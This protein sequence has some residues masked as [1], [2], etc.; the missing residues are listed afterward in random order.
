MRQNLTLIESSGPELY[1]LPTDLRLNGH[2][3]TM[4]MHDRWLYS[5]LRLTSSMAVRGAALDLFLLA[6]KQA[7]LGTLPCDDDELASLLHLSKGEWLKLKAETPNPLYGW[8]PCISDRGEAR[9]MHPVV[10]EVTDAT[11]SNRDKAVAARDESNA[12]KRVQRLRDQIAAMGASRQANDPLV[13]EW[14]DQ[15]LAAHCPGR[16]RTAAQVQRALEEHAAAV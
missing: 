10:L 13:V 14:V 12:R 6:Q 8:R 15:W 9:L 2:Y 7:P 1:P 16:N 5:R 3:L 11:I 4:L